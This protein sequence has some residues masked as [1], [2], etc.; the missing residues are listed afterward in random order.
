MTN[1]TQQILKELQKYTNEVVLFS[2]AIGKDS[3][4]LLDLLIKNGF[5]VN[6]ILM[7]VCKDLTFVNNYVRWAETKYN[8]KFTIVPAYFLNS[9]YK[10]GYLGL[11][12]QD[13][14]N[15]TLSQLNKKVC[16]Q[17]DI[18]WTIFGFKKMDGL[19]RRIML[20]E[21]PLSAFFY[22]NYK[23]Y[24]LADWTNKECLAYIK[25]NKLITP[26]VYNTKKP[27]SDIELT[28]KLFL[29]WLEKYYPQDL[30]KIFN[31]FPETEALFELY[32]NEN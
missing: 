24:P 16:E 19:N 30:N 17:L 29:F 13:I 25:Q 20:N 31:T 22:K 27:S 18:N 32:K 3:I 14:P 10:T 8:V 15:Q 2:S 23:C 5:K 6:P 21:L 9:W 11:E 26:V 1:K 28:D 7:Y 4:V 12:I